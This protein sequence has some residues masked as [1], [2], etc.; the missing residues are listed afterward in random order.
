MAMCGRCD[1]DGIAQC[2]THG[3]GELRPFLVDSVQDLT[4]RLREASA[5][6]ERAEAELARVRPVVDAAEALVEHRAEG[7]WKATTR[8]AALWDKRHGGLLDVLVAAVKE[9]QR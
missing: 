6:A 1:L 8:E 9:A 3:A 2:P 5:R 4:L 7:S